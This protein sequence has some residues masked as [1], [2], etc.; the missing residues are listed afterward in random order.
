MISDEKLI[1]LSRRGFFPG[2]DE[3]E[4]EFLSRVSFWKQSN[5]IEEGKERISETDLKE[6]HQITEDLFDF[7]C[8][9]VPCLYDDEKLSLWQGAVLWAYQ[10]EEGRE[11]PVVQLR[12]RFKKGRFLGY[13]RKEVLSHELVHA[14]RFKFDDPYFEE[15]FAYRT[16]SRKFHAVFG[17][18]FQ[19]HWEP[20]VL[21]ASL[22][23]ACFGFLIGIDSDAW[24]FFTKLIYIPFVILGLFL[25]RL[26][27]LHLLLMI[28]TEKISRIMNQSKRALA[29]MIRLTDKEIFKFSIHPKKSIILYFQEKQHQSLRIR[30]IYLSYL[31]DRGL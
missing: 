24:P 22:F 21:V 8:C 11:R 23:L 1:D 4:E 15:M 25:L 2:P 9:D 30:A 20:F 19:S 27:L 14:A 17:P 26:G 10:D 7:S 29:F 3:K 31:R 16:S 5:K 12:K 6:A 13:S 18:L 28:C